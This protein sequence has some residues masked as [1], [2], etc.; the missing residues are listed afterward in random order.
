MCAGLCGTL[1]GSEMSKFISRWTKT[2]DSIV[3][4]LGLLVCSPILFLALTLGN[5]NMYLSWVRRRSQYNYC[6]VLYIAQ[7]VYTIYVIHRLVLF[8][9]LF[10]YIVPRSLIIYGIWL[11]WYC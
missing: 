4:A 6:V 5:Y 11:H 9:P 7:V 8:V 2:S 10:R 3:C 1:A